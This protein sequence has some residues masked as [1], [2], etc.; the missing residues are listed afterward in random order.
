MVCGE[1]SI[2]FV[3][4][5]PKNS[6][7]EIVLELLATV[8]PP[9][10]LQFLIRMWLNGVE[11]RDRLVGVESGFYLQIEVTGNHRSGSEILL[12]HTGFYVRSMKPFT[13]VSVYVG[14]TSFLSRMPLCSSS[15][16]KESPGEYV[17]L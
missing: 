13:A 11:L 16:R 6:N 10:N 17:T 8:L 4:T 5:L 9:P 12:T 3:A 14:R 15:R 1:G 2:Q 7:R